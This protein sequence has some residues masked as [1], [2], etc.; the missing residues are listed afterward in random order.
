MVATVADIRAAGVPTDS[1][2]CL[3][4]RR[5]E[6]GGNHGILPFRD[7][8]APFMT[9]GLP[10]PGAP[11]HRVCIPGYTGHIAGKIAENCHG[12][13]FR[14]ENELVAQTLPL[15]RS[16]MRRSLSE[17]QS[18]ATA[19]AGTLS[20]TKGLSVAPRV[21]GYMGAIPGKD[22]ETVHGLRFAEASEAAGA[23]RQHNP[24]VS[25]EGW[26][27]R[28]HWAADPLPSYNWNN[29]FVSSGGFHLFTPEQEQEAHEVSQKLGRTFGF[30][31]A[32]H[33]KY[34]P[35]DRFLHSL[36]QKK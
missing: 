26:M 22:S 6:S 4:P 23:L 16:A 19:A 32:K 11:R 30:K 28:G 33:S 18:L 34:K 14:I 35:G 13:T 20:G 15:R 2:T 24:H 25:C 3:L 21:P 12:G 5:G 8:Q 17:P 9:G 10:H 31:T 27:R 7:S 36:A 29:R 1:G